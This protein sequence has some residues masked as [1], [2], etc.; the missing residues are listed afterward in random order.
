MITSDYVYLVI[1]KHAIFFLFIDLML[2]VLFNWSSNI[3]DIAR[4]A[5]S[6]DLDEEVLLCKRKLVDILILY[7]MC[8]LR[9]FVLSKI[10]R[11]NLGSSASTIA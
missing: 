11:L 9:L 8:Y 1:Q 6:V 7:H 10:C 2:L 5:G 4:D 3:E